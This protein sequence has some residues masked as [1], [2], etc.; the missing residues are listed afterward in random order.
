MLCRANEGEL[1][2]IMDTC[3]FSMKQ[4]VEEL[5]FPLPFCKHRIFYSLI[6]PLVWLSWVRRTLGEDTE[7]KDTIPSCSSLLTRQVQTH[8]SPIHKRQSCQCSS[9]CFFATFLVPLTH[10]ECGAFSIVL[11]PSLSASVEEDREWG[12]EVLVTDNPACQTNLPFSCDSLNNQLD[13]SSECPE[14]SVSPDPNV[15]PLIIKLMGEQPVV[16]SLGIIRTQWNLHFW[17]PTCQLGSLCQVHPAVSEVHRSVLAL[18]IFKIQLQSGTR[19]I[20][21]KG[22]AQIHW[23]ALWR[24][25]VISGTETNYS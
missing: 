23:S 15:Q 5:S 18:S 11:G 24:R 16:W 25:K 8:C 1:Y 4:Q 20:S 22:K 12:R 14:G 17:A 13:S 2:W 9:L 21:A 7:E 10:C 6:F 3:C 19:R